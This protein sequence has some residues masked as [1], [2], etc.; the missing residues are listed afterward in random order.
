M[1]D[2]EL[3]NYCEAH[4]QTERA[5]F[6]AEHINRMLELAGHPEGFVQSVTGWMSLH[7]QMQELVDLARVRRWNKGV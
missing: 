3:I 1:T 2:D 7:G 6:S 4:C 5:L